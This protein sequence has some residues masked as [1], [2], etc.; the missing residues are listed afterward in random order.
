MRDQELACEHHCASIE[1]VLRTCATPGA[2]GRID[3]RY[4]WDGTR[5]EVEL[6][7]EGEGLERPAA[8]VRAAFERFVPCQDDG[9]SEGTVPL[10]FAGG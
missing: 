2:D 8:C 4:G 3:V 6:D 5:T 9:P 10:R 1:P 7:I